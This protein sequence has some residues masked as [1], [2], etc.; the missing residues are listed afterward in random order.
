MSEIAHIRIKPTLLLRTLNLTG[1]LL[2][3]VRGDKP[4]SVPEL[5][6]KASKL[7][8]LSDYGNMVFEDGLH[9]YV[10]AVNRDLSLSPW[11]EML[12]EMQIVKRLG[13]R[14]NTVEALRQHPELAETPIPLTTIVVGTPRSGTTFLY[15]LLSLDP[16]FRTPSLWEVLDP[17]PPASVAPADQVQRRVRKIEREFIWLYN[18][19]H[20]KHRQVHHFARADQKEECYHIMEQTFCWSSLGIV[21]GHAPKY[22]EWLFAQSHER[23]LLSYSYLATIIR[24]LMF[25]H[26]SKRWLSKSPWHASHLTALAETLPDARVIHTH[27]D[28][29]ER[30]TSLASLLHVTQSVFLSPVPSPEAFG[31]MALEDN[32][33]YMAGIHAARN[34]AIAPNTR[35]IDYR[36]LTADP[37]KTVAE[38]YDSYGMEFSAEFESRIRQWLEEE[39]HWSP[40]KVGVHR[41]SPADFGLDPNHLRSL[42]P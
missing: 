15:N 30:I 37:I 35:D 23:M 11:G 39:N 9:A 5:K 27:R 21:C 4:L 1:S 26:E 13:A 25:G 20:P 34:S 38:L 2:Q 8:G 22:L 18:K 29:V 6:R 14:L 31:R 7:T 42:E 24:A 17:M 10:E 41:Y 33:R 12:T 3:R 40:K 19:V 32:E 28:P 36:A 16:N